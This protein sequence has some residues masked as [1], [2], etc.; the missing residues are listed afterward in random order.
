M[1]IT[2]LAETVTLALRDAFESVDSAAVARGWLAVFHDDVLP[3]LAK[4]L[5]DET[6]AAG[7]LT[8]ATGTL[9]HIAI[10]DTDEA[11]AYLKRLA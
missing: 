5:S 1:T 9:A 3:T 10:G 4:Q 8:P 6:L 2:D 11:I 7:I